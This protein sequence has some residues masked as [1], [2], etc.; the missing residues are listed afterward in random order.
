MASPET[1]AFFAAPLQ[2]VDV[3]SSVVAYR[4]FGSGPPLLL[5]HGWPLSG[6]TYRRLIPHLADRFTCY[7]VDLPGAGETH[8][9]GQT[10]F[11]FRGQAETLRRVLDAL[12]LDG[13]HV[14][15]HD[16]GA[17]IARGLALIAGDR[18]GDLFLIGTEIPGHRP[19]WIPLFQRLAALPGAVSTFRLSL[20]SDWFVR[21][22]MGF[23]NCFVD[24]R[25]LGGDFAEHIIRPLRESRAKLDGQLRYLRG[26]DWQFVDGLATA[27]RAIANRVLLIWGAE[28]SIFPAA[29]ARGMV[30]QFAACRGLEVVPDAKLLVHEERPEAVAAHVLSAL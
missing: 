4:R 22:P 16:T 25:L 9:T 17:S 14:V 28:D 8:W 24:R 13:C 10:D 30:S 15:A 26:I 1:E 2:H 18:L 5:V 7:A 6:F 12:H 3:G 23:G 11:G 19:P 27:H 21:S 29:R 20:S